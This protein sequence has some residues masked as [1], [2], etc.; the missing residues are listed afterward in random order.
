MK[1]IKA[2][3]ALA[4]PVLTVA[5]AAFSEVSAQDASTVN[6]YLRASSYYADLTDPS[7]SKSYW[8]LSDSEQITPDSLP[9]AA[10]AVEGINL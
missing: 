3:S 6:Y 9:G 2:L 4:V 5:A 8:S 7:Y 10:A 1:Y